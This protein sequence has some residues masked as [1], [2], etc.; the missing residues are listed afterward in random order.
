MSADSNQETAAL[1]AELRAA[2]RREAS[3]RVETV[4]DFLVSGE[5]N[6]YA[7]SLRNERAALVQRAQEASSDLEVLAQKLEAA[8]RR[9][10]ALTEELEQAKGSFAWRVA[11][12]FRPA[13]KLQTNPGLGENPPAKGGPFTYYLHTSP[14]R[15]YREDRFTLRGWA[16][17]ESGEAVTGVRANVD[18]RLFV[19]RLGLEEPDVIAR[20]GPQASN[21]KPG[22]E[23]T[24]DT[25][26]GRHQLS[27]EAQV[28][29]GEWRT[30]VATAIW[31]E[32]LG[33]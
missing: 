25:P 14:F 19:G 3:F 10:E 28:G 30:I 27:I 24:F 26:P 11:R 15:V 20:Y 22:F 7:S 18:G 23:V 21:P 13:P 32:A 33:G 5:R 17:P 31:C 4:K 16:W 1:L 2:R 12:L 9:S 29:G 8:V 6:T